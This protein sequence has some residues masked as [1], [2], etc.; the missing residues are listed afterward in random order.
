M[1]AAAGGGTRFG[2]PKQFLTLAGQPLLHGSL[3]IFAAVEEIAQ[4]VVV[5]PATDL[6]RTRELVETWSSAGGDSRRRARLVVEVVE[7]GAR[8][9]DSVLAGLET[10]SSR[11]EWVLVHDAAR[12]LVRVGDVR[13]VLEAVRTHGAAVLGTPCVDSIKRVQD[14]QIVEELP[15]DEVWTVQTPQGARLE[16]LRAAYKQFPD[17]SWTDEASALRRLGVAVELV[18]GPRENL[19]ITRPGD[20]A[21][22]EFLLRSRRGEVL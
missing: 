11:V 9:Q 22:A 3:G 19:K 17:D 6:E 16:L 2:G 20:E 14:G 1:L 8:R 18:E 13:R 7:G 21:L 10:L 15:R 4:V 12:P 5:A